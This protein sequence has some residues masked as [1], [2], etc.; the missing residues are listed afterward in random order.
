V[1]HIGSW[2]TNELTINWNAPIAWVA[3]FLAEQGDGSVAEP[4]S[5][6][7]SYRATSVFGVLAG[8]AVVRNTGEA[9]IDGWTL[10]WTFGGNQR[11]LFAVGA[12]LTQTG[13]DVTAINA[14]WNATV[15]PGRSTTF[16]FFGT[17]KGA[18]PTPQ[19]FTLNGTV[20]S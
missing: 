12:D 1:D 10:Q 15:E 4:V 20:C 2:S 5:C 11:I 6:A 9:A 8:T 17:S 3:S 19:Q 18:N 7:V 13:A 16:L 14:S